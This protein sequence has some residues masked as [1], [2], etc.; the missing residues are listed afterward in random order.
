MLVIDTMID[1]LRQHLT[2][3]DLLR[4]QND[5]AAA[6][7]KNGTLSAENRYHEA[8]PRLARVAD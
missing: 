2:R 3:E 8:V 6:V 5:A 4:I 1:G 7:S